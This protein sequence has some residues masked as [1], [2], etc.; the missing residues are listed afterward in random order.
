MLIELPFRSP[1]GD[2]ARVQLRVG[3]MVDIDVVNHGYRESEL[4]DPGM[5]ADLQGRHNALH[6]N[7]N[8][9]L[10]AED[11]ISIDGLGEY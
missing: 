2:I 3:W 11:L 1:N 8:A 4:T 9:P 10:V 7:G 6:P 5:V